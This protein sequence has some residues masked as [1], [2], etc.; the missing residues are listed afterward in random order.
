M[1]IQHETAGKIRSNY[2]PFLSFSFFSFFPFFSSRETA[3]V[4]AGR[5]KQPPFFGVFKA[6]KRQLVKDSLSENVHS[7]KVGEK[8][9]L[10][11]FQETVE[12]CSRLN[13]FISPPPVRHLHPEDQAAL[14]QPSLPLHQDQPGRHADGD[15]AAAALPALARGPA[16][17]QRLLRARALQVQRHR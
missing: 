1:L 13:R 5:S 10:V 2:F 12:S 8:L 17:R 11:A 15:Q 4:A 9:G 3:Q 6:A 14:Q 7:E 16:G